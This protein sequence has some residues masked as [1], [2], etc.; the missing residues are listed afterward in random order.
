VIRF[1]AAMALV[2]TIVGCGGSADDVDA[3]D[4]ERSAYELE[5]TRYRCTAEAELQTLD[6]G[7]WVTLQV[8]ETAE[9]CSPG[10]EPGCG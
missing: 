2:T 7:A 5:Q 3:Q 10:P 1:I 9:A 4:C 6:C 8:C